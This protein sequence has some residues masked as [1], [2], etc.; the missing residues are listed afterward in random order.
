MPIVRAHASEILSSN[1]YN[2]ASESEW[3]LAFENNLISGNN[4]IEELADR[5]RGSY[6]SKFCDGRPFL[7]GGWLM[8]SSR[9]WNS[10]TP[11]TSQINRDQNSAYLRIVKR[12]KNHIFSDTSPQL[13]K[14]SN[15]SE[16]LFEEL[17]I[18]L[19]VGIAP[20]FLWAY[21]NASGRYITEGWLN[22]VFGGLF[23]GVFTIIFWRPRTK[24]WRI[25]QNCGKMKSFNP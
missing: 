4:E 12:P 22:L 5:I 19:I 24:S 18:A 8:K 6:W 2:I 14:S 15:K 3:S 10:G 16:L 13:P 7:E 20:S 9:T 23:I 1:E 21:F 11:S 17:F 25:G